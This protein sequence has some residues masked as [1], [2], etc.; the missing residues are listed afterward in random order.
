MAARAGGR[1]ADKSIPRLER[2]PPELHD[3]LSSRRD[4][5]RERPVRKR[6]S[7]SAR[8][9]RRAVLLLGRALMLRCPNC[10]RG[11]LF[12]SWFRLKNRCPGCALEL[13][14]GEHDH[15]LGAMMFNIVVAEGVFVLGFVAVLLATWP[16]PPWALLEYGGVAAMIAAPFAFYPL[17]RAIWLAFD[18]ML[19]PVTPEDFADAPDRRQA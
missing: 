17:S 10:G 16:S 14:R 8:G 13:D 5:S 15:F 2:K 3:S 11:G 7:E 1:D 19:R 12:A 9:V 4:V 6:T 18:I